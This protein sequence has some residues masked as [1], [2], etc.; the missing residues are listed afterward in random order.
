[1]KLIIGLGNPGKEYTHTRHNVGFLFIDFLREKLGFSPFTTD[2]KMLAET[3]TGAIN[4]E[5]IVLVKPTSFMNNSG[6]TV[7]NL[8]QFYKLSSQDIIVIHDDLDI[9]TGSYKQTFSSRSAGHNGVQD[10]INKLG[11][12][13]F[14]RIRI[15]I[16][17]PLVEKGEY[18]PIEKY[19]LH[20]FL[21]EEMKKIQGLF[22]TVFKTFLTLFALIQKP[23]GENKN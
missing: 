6:S 1:M 22:P 8:L 19:V 7:Q 3:S 18:I 21:P 23:T 20:N 14:L 16:D 4:G 9:T 12:Q 17:K 15:G 13:D 2:A 10:I 11:T 5:K